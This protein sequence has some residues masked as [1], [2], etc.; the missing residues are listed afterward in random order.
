MWQVK[1]VAPIWQAQLLPLKPNTGAQRITQNPR[2]KL[3]HRNQVINCFWLPSFSLSTTNQLNLDSHSSAWGTQDLSVKDSMTC[4]EG[5]KGED[6]RV[7]SP[8]T[9]K[10]QGANLLFLT[11]RRNV[12]KMTCLHHRVVQVPK[13]IVRCFINFI[14]WSCMVL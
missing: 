11:C 2:K 8:M 13:E 12:V 6:P 9:V 3:Q 5:N 14:R 1:G 4:W 10:A 7:S